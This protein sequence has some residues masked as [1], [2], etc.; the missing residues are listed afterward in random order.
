METATKVKSPC[1]SPGYLSSNGFHDIES[2]VS[3]RYESSLVL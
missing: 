1:I 3:L 2:V